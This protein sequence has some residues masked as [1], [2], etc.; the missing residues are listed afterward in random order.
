MK[1]EVLCVTPERGGGWAPIT[2]MA[3]LAADCFGSHVRFIHPERL[4]RPTE[5]LTAMLPRRPGR[6]GS[7]LAIVATPADLI[8]VASLKTLLG[9]LSTVSAWLIDS[10]WTDRLPRMARPLR[11]VDHLF[12]T[13]PEL[14]EFYAGMTRV[15][16]TWLPWGTDTQGPA[17]L[18]GEQKDIDVF[19]LGRQPAIWDDDDVNRRAFAPLRYQGRFP[20]HTDADTNSGTVHGYLARSKVVLASTNTADDA[21]YTHPHRDYISARWCDASAAGCVVVGAKPRTAATDILPSFGLVDVDVANPAAA[22]AAARKAASDWT[23]ELGRRIREHAVRHLDWRHRFLTIAQTLSLDVSRLTELTESLD[24]D[25][26]AAT[27]HGEDA[28]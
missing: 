6:R 27:G 5:K 13:D 7:L 11:N 23:P 3:T 18:R 15:P 14:I 17:L 9:G 20:V 26:S 1:V 2:T 16:V 25:V 4:Y 12:I 21:D 10:F 8:A 24:C 28:Q 19:R 22:N